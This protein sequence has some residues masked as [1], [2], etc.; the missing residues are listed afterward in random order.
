M[1][2]RMTMTSVSI[3]E[4]T[5]IAVYAAFL[6]IY[7]G[8]SFFGIKRALTAAAVVA[9]IVVI[10]VLPSAAALVALLAAFVGLIALTAY[11]HKRATVFSTSAVV[12]FKESLARGARG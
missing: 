5:L 2:R 4:L 3:R 11:R 7:F 10:A 6:V 8:Y 12:M 9:G 1:L